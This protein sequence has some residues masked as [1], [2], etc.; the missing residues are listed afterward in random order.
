[1]QGL[2]E[3][4]DFQVRGVTQGGSGRG[5]QGGGG[6]GGGG[7]VLLRLQGLIEYIETNQP[8]VPLRLAG[9]DGCF[10]II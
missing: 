2:N 1:M 4:I 5:S 7:G 6:G 8:D 9:S 3:Y 10:Y